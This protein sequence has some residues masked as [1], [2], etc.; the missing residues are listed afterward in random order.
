MQNK[1]SF[2]VVFSDILIEVVV[3]VSIGLPDTSYYTL[4]VK[5]ENS[6]KVLETKKSIL[7][8]DTQNMINSLITNL[9]ELRK[10]YE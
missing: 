10:Y 6:D 1:Y 7:Y 3:Y 2:E 9:D 8:K 4:T 5:L